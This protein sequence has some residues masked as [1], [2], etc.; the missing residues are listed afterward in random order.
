MLK[1][2]AEFRW[3]KECG[4]A[5]AKAKEIL[6]SDRVLAH[7]S[8][9]IPVKVTCDASNGGIGAVLS[10]LYSDGSERP[11]A[12]MS[13]VLSDCERHYSMI[14]K[15]ALAIYSGVKK[16]ENLMGL[17]FI[18]IDHKPLLAI[19]GEKKGLPV[20]A[21]SRL[22]RWAIYLSSFDYTI[23]YIKGKDNSRADCLS[24]LPEGKKPDDNYGPG[25]YLNFIHE[26]SAMV[27]D[28]AKIRFETRR[29][30]LLSRLY[31]RVSKGWSI[32]LDDRERE[33]FRTIFL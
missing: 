8:P 25:N 9:D 22:Q 1:D 6:V 30:K 16:F 4:E 10:H 15:E 19:F 26:Q 2:K 23:R 24:R 12:F 32:V 33:R 5:L 21:A 7:F 28:A 18:E 11:I 17:K 14:D 13:R 29:D 20:L 27:I 31:E 3:S